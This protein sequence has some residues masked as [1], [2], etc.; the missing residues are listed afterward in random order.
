MFFIENFNETIKS[1]IN[2]IDFNNKHNEL[3]LTY[4][5]S[6]KIFN[7]M[8]KYSK[9]A[10]I[11]D[12]I[13]SYLNIDDIFDKSLFFD[14]KDLIILEN[15]LFNPLRNGYS[16]YSYR[17]SNWF[18]VPSSIKNITPEDFQ[19]VE[20]ACVTAEGDFI[21]NINYCEKLCRYAK[22][23]NLKGK[24]GK[25]IS[26]GGTI[27]DFYCLVETSI[28]HEL[29]HISNGDHFYIDFVEGVDPFIHNLASD[30]II[31]FN[32]KKKGHLLPP[33][34]L[35]SSEISFENFNS[36]THI[37]N[38]ILENISINNNFTT[39]EHQNNVKSIKNI[40][41]KEFEEISYES[42][43]NSLL[44]IKSNKTT[45]SSNFKKNQEF[46]FFEEKPDYNWEETFKL[47]L[48]SFDYQLESSYSKIN[49]RAISNFKLLQETGITA[50][51][52]G[53]VLKE[54]DRV[55]LLLVID[56]SQSV[57][58]KLNYVYNN[59]SNLIHSK[60]EQ[61][62]N[63]SIIKFDSKFTSYDFTISSK[64]IINI[65]DGNKSKLN[66]FFYSKKWGGGTSYNEK[67]KEEISKYINNN[68][69][70][71]LFSD[72][73]L[74]SKTNVDNFKETINEI[75]KLKNP[76]VFICSTFEDYSSFKKEEFP[77]RNIS[78]F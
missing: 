75:N 63:L 68:F 51:K 25:Y 47:L 20:N 21:F 14:L 40:S 52:P 78:H 55:N 10:I 16:N 12:G 54:P 56:N 48:P 39:Q 24:G 77:I 67:L 11:F 17:N 18:L 9:E 28:L 4:N 36:M 59:I 3:L 15:K 70:I 64:F 49:N 43:S 41:F 30:F 34:F 22:L 6:K 8:T 44:S 60:Q 23:Y 61:I 29:Y 65:K 57:W 74:L 76:F 50:V 2:L 71:A 53:Y 27:P 58:E 73:D 33:N 38:F 1:N 31:N 32:L 37:R 13:L 19:L 35:Y 26:N 5:Q 62:I 46:V 69:S 66:D 72:K 42:I 7:D 45:P